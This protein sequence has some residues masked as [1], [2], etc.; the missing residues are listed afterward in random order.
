V[1][2]ASGAIGAATLAQ[3]AAAFHDLHRRT[4]GHDNRSEPV[5][6]VNVRLTA[7]GAIPPLAV[8]DRPAPPGTDA[9][10]ARRRLWFRDA[11]A[12]EAV[13]Y[14]RARMPA[15][16]TARGPAVIESLEST[17]LVPPGWQARMNDEG[18]VVMKQSRPS[19]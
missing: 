13:V 18:F 19:P 17:I 4:Y 15:G 7:I 8:R 11:G 1:P 12:V 16:L 10:K 2:V 5:Q 9:V 3:I 6:I 14:D